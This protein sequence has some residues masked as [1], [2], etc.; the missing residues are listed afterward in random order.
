MNAPAAMFTWQD[1]I[2]IFIYNIISK[3]LLLLIRG[4]QRKEQINQR[5]F[6]FVCSIAASES[7]CA[8]HTE[9]RSSDMGS[10]SMTGNSSYIGTVSFELLC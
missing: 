4:C 6:S 10:S 8:G 3:D 7:G 2:N 1:A 9:Q 5:S